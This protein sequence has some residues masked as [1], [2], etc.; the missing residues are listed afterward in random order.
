VLAVIG[1]ALMGFL[2]FDL[3][4][5]TGSVLEATATPQPGAA[6]VVPGPTDALGEPAAG[7]ASSPQGIA[8]AS[9]LPTAASSTTERSTGP[10]PEPTPAASTARP[11]PTSDRYAVLTPCPGETDCYQYVVRSGDNLASIA[12]WFGI[13]YQTVLALNPQIAD[14]GTV[15]AGDRIRLPTPRR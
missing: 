6:Q 9:A 3:R 2:I 10:S 8:A 7:G 14:P 5:P 12:N 4:G 15:H 13:S 11:G 1:L